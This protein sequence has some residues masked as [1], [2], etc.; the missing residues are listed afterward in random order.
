METATSLAWVELPDYTG[1]KVTINEEL[2]LIA[3]AHIDYDQCASNPLE[4]C[5]GIGEIRSFSHN[6]GNFIDP[7]EAKAMM[8]KNKYI[9]L[10]SYYEHGNCLW[11]VKDHDPTWLPDKQWDGVEYA[12][13]WVPDSCIMESMLPAIKYECKDKGIDYKSLSKVERANLRK[14]WMIRQ[15]ESACEVYTQ[16]CNGEVY[17]YNIEV[18]TIRKHE[19][20]DILDEKSDYRKDAPVED[21]SCG[22]FYGHDEVVRAAKEALGI[23]PE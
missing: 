9:I 1:E 17:W 16:Y 7:D 22:G 13:I 14:D 3:F 20:G 21:E 11:Y 15:A 23:A 19:N 10:L 18:Y 5:D 12:G 4:D 2:G 8:K 6:H